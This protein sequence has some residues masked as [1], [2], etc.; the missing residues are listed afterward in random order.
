MNSRARTGGRRGN[1]V[2]RTIP[3]GLHHSAQGG[4]AERLPWVRI[5]KHFQPQRGCISGRRTLLQPLQGCFHFGGVTQG[6]SPT[7]NPGLMDGIPLGF[8]SSRSDDVTVAVGFIPRWKRP[9]SRVAERRLNSWPSIS[10]VATRRMNDGPTCPWLESHS[11]H[12]GVAPRLS[13]TGRRASSIP[14]GF[15]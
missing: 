11:Y 13:A 3:K 7:R 6:S 10:I 1:A 8:I 5:Q 2:L 12:H 14:L 15:N 4:R 9:T